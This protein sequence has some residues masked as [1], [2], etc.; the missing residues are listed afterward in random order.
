MLRCHHVMCSLVLSVFRLWLRL[1]SHLPGWLLIM[2]T[3]KITLSLDYS[4]K[5]WMGERCCH[6][7]GRTQWRT[8]LN[9]STVYIHRN[10]A[11]F[12]YIHVSYP[13]YLR[14]T[15]FTTTKLPK[16]HF[17]YHLLLFSFLSGA[18]PM[19]LL[20]AGAVTARPYPR[21]PA[22][23][24]QFKRLHHWCVVGC[25][26]TK[27]LAT[28]VS[29]VWGT[30]GIKAELL[31]QKRNCWQLCPLVTHVIRRWL[32]RFSRRF[33]LRC[34]IGSNLLCLWFDTLM[35][36]SSPIATPSSVLIVIA[37]FGLFLPPFETR[38]GGSSGNGRTS[39][40]EH[41]GCSHVLQNWYGPM[42]EWIGG[43]M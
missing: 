12:T 25:L 41:C 24:A 30:S 14:L 26:Q 27:I 17:I 18:P 29:Q 37:V 43:A 35:A 36:W 8:P 15:I 16:C 22:I 21:L 40:D 10:E 31:C 6:L 1:L 20:T 39:S 7:S 28:P 11:H 9:S 34:L 19:T 33:S 2:V 3:N 4:L 5:Q 32:S 23:A 38:T 13:M 42:T